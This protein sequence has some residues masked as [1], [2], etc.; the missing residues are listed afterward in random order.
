MS[1]VSKR[2]TVKKIK[3]SYH[4]QMITLYLPRFLTVHVK[5]ASRP[6]GYVTFDMLPWNS[7]ST[8]YKISVLNL[9]ENKEKKTD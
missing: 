8:S 1:S 6:A 2:L 5:I 9:K 4:K 3:V 7:G